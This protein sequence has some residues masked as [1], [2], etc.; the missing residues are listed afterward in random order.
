VQTP[1]WVVMFR[2]RFTTRMIPLDGRPH[3]DP[4]IQ[5]WDGNSVGRFEGNTLVVE[6]TNFSDKQIGGGV[7]NPVPRG[8][9]FGNIRLI[10]RFV[11]VGPNRIHFYATLEDPKTWTRPW[12]FMV[13]WEKNPDYQ[14]LEYACHEGNQVVALSLRG[15]RAAEAARRSQQPSVSKEQTSAALVGITEAELRTRLGNPARVEFEGARW[16]Y[17]T[18]SGTL[19]L[20]VFLESG[21]VKIVQPNDLPLDQVSRR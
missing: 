18:R 15:E 10:E 4:T 9:P 2:E 3:V 19:V 16:V 1:G 7:G 12:T 20:N 5:M 11:P 17:E 14:L 13:P 21:K 8:I 6:T